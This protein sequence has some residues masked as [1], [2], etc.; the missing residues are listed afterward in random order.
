[1]ILAKKL[2][3]TLNQG[4]FPQVES[5]STRTGNGSD[6]RA[7]YPSGIQAGDMLIA[8]FVHTTNRST[9]TPAGFATLADITRNNTNYRVCYKIANGSESGS[10]FGGG[11]SIAGSWC[12]W[13]YRISGAT[14]IYSS[15]ARSTNSSPNPPN[16]DPGLG[17]QNF[18]WFA[19]FGGGRNFDTN[20][21][22]VSAIPAGYADESFLTSLRNVSFNR[23]RTSGSVTWKQEKIASDD[24]SS[25]STNRSWDWNAVTIAVG[26]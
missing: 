6:A 21:Y 12:A 10:A 20:S 14:S 26:A 2:L 19:A 3:M 18:L 5:F 25:F 22:T 9:N 16:L 24:P 15:N 17:S 11:E 13:M 7:D 1:M 8:F 23:S 4:S